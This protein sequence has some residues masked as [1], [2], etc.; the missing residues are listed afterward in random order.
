MKLQ[1]T[2]PHRKAPQYCNAICVLCGA[3][4]RMQLASKHS[5][6]LSQSSQQ[7]REMCDL[8]DAALDVRQNVPAEGP[9]R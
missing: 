5:T 4:A 8:I 7:I 3:A 2:D 9:G 6:D 1:H